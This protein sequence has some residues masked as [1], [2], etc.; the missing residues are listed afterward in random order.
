MSQKFANA[1]KNADLIKNFIF[2]KVGE[3][4]GPGRQDKRGSKIGNVKNYDFKKIAKLTSGRASPL[5]GNSS[6]RLYVCHSGVSKVVRRRPASNV[7]SVRTVSTPTLPA[8]WWLLIPA[9][10]A[11]KG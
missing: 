9:E 5:V 8:G 7:G 6:E 3:L 1:N 10:R 11:T 2:A 4:A